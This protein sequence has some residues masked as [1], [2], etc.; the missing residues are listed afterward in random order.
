MH[1]L[2]QGLEEI[3][4]RLVSFLV[5]GHDPDRSLRSLH[6]ALDTHLNVAPFRGV[7]LLELGPQ[8]PSHVAL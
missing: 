5:S 3:S 8:F 6:T 7:L 2:D 1:I 4:V